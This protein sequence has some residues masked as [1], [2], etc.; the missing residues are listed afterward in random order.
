M[1]RRFGLGVTPA[2]GGGLS[3]GLGGFM[4]LWLGWPHANSAAHLPFAL[5]ALLRSDQV[6]LRRDWLIRIQT[7]RGI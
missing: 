4:M 7:T 6:G 5:Y 1:L 2:I 3:Y